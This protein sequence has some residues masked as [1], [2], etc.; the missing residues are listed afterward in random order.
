CISWARLRAASAFEGAA[1]ANAKVAKKASGAAM[2]RRWGRTRNLQE[3]SAFATTERTQKL[4]TVV[5]RFGTGKARGGAIRGKLGPCR[6][7][8]VSARRR[9]GGFFPCAESPARAPSPRLR[10]ARDRARRNPA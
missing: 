1:C 3:F 7:A 9:R 10:R 8:G 5:D 2:R 6:Q 4:L